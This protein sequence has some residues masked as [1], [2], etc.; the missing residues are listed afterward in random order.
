M[1]NFGTCKTILTSDKGRI[2]DL[3]T[4]YNLGDIIFVSCSFNNAE[5][6][7]AHLDKYTIMDD[8]TVKNLS[9]THETILFTGNSSAEFVSRFAGINTG[10]ADDKNVFC[11][12]R[13]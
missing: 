13:S 12:K 9:G 5:P 2:I 10:S 7:V 1:K 11:Y 6:V 8:F 3:L 4:L